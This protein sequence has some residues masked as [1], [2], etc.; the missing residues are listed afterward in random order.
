MKAVPLLAASA[1]PPKDRCHAKAECGQS[2]RLGY[3]R[4]ADVIEARV[5]EPD[6]VISDGHETDDPSRCTI[7]GGNKGVREERPARSEAGGI[8]EMSDHDARV[9]AGRSV[10]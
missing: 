8:S 7:D 6:A 2:R 9:E 5:G 3:R 4:Q 1:A 10:Q